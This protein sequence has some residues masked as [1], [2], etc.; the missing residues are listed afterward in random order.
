MGQKLALIAAIA[1]C[2]SGNNGLHLVL[3]GSGV[4]LRFAAPRPK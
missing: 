4:R 2:T 3:T 1:I